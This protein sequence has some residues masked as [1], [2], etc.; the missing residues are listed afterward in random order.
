MNVHL[1]RVSRIHTRSWY[2][3]QLPAPTG[4]DSL[5]DGLRVRTAIIGAGLAGLST[6]L[7]LAERGDSDLVVI[8]RGRIGEGASGRNG[9]FVF[10]GFSLDPVALAGKVGQEQ[11]RRMHRWTRSA[12][13]TIDARCRRWNV[14]AARQGVVL[15]DWFHDTKALR[16]FRDRMAA[17]LDFELDWISP[18]H[19]PDWVRSKRYG[20][21]LHEPGSLHINPLAYVHALAAAVRAAGGRICEQ[22]PVV[23]LARDEDGWLLR[24][25]RGKIRAERV[26]LATGGYDCMLQPRW[27]RAVLPIGTYIAVTEPLDQRLPD[28]IPAGVAV[29]DTRFAFDYYRPLADSRLLWGGRISIA[30]RDPAAIRRVLRRDM[31]RVFPAL[32]DVAFDYAWGGWMSYARHQMPLLGEVEPGLWLALGF[33]GHGLAPTTLAG[34]V[35]AESIIGDRARLELFSQFQARW[36]GGAA[37]RLAAQ[38]VYWWK[39]ALDGARSLRRSLRRRG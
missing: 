4:L 10:A 38:V 3:D 27:Q 13:K 33:G 12:V 8:E 37:G 21:G 9:G 18:E 23:E 7:G 6:A 29:Y 5:E 20:A 16:R 19:L 34:E 15:A 14:P 32:A 17:A 39:Q 36:A 30:D 28:L 25:R 24:T 31:L 22:Q 11:A 1:A 2:Q 35:L 26:V